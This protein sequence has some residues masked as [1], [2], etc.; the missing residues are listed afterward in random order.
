MGDEPEVRRLI[1]E[2]AAMAA[3][4]VHAYL[5][6]GFAGYLRVL[7][8]ESETG[9]AAVDAALRRSSVAPAAPGQHAVVQRLQVAAFLAAGDRD[10]ALAAANRLLEA[11]GP[12]QLWAPLAH[13]V[14]ADLGGRNAR[15]TPVERARNGR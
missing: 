13:R 11:G 15:G 4:G 5:A 2:F 7:D 9:L 12:A 1:E 8:G 10:G 3:D 14:L 6:G